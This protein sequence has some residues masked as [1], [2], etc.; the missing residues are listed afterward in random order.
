MRSSRR[1]ILA[2]PLAALG[3]SLLARAGLAEEAKTPGV[4]ASDIKIGQTM[5]YSGPASAYAQVGR[6]EAAYFRTINAAGG[7]N[8]RTI[9]LISLDDGY[10]PPKA[11]EQT[12]RLVEQEHVAAIFGTLG[13]PINMAIRRYLNQNHVPQ[14]FVAAGSDNFASPKTAPW[15][16][17]WQP[18]L[19]TEAMFYARHVLAKTPNAKIAAIYQNDDFGKGLLGGLKEG[20]GDRAGEMILAAESFEATD[21]TIDSQVIAM[22]GSGAD[23]VFLF[24]YAKQAAQAIRKIAD[25]NWHP[26]RYLHLGSA[27]VAATFIPAGLAQS[28]GIMTAGFLKDVAD[29]QWADDPDVKAWRV[30]LRAAMPE[31]DEKDSLNVAGYS[32]AQTLVQVLRQCGDDLSRPNIMRQA[33]NLHDFRLPMLLPG[34]LI[35]TRPDDYRVITTMR[36]QRFTGRGWEFLT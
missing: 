16:I 12:R 31:A 35:N 5:P 22:H 10:S 17:G 20:L 6:A 28:T 4:T 24:A 1:A 19:R 27:S 14:L 21:P 3:A 18:T 29:P 15:S 25:L 32:Y 13:T 34:I 7:V 36:L 11:V 2:A 9:T 30:W 8:G 23:T 26:E 33:T